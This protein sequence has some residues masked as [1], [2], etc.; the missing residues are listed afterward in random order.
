MRKIFSNPAVFSIAL[1]ISGCT[2]YQ[3]LPLAQHARLAEHIENIRHTLPALAGETA[4]TD[5]DITRPLTVAQIGLLAI[6]NAPELQTER[7]EQAVAEA[8]LIQ[9]A[10]LP[11]PSVG[12]GYAALLG[13]PGT[14][15][16]YTASLSQDIAS[17]VTYRRRVAAARAGVEQVNANLLWK[18]WQVAQKA[19]LLAVD[20]YWGI[21]SIS[22]ME[23]ELALVSQTT[24]DVRNAVA[25]GDMGL[26]DLAPVQDSKATTERSLESLRESQSANWQSLD[27][28]L[29][30][31]P[32]V[33]F[34]IAKPNLP[35]LP[36][37]SDALVANV[38]SRRPDLVALQLGYR[39]ADESVRAAILGQFPALVLGGTWG[40]DTS[41]IRSAG[42][43]VT[44]D[45]PIFD[46]NQ[47]QVAQTQATR[48]LL[49]EQYQQQLDDTVSSILGLQAKSQRIAATLETARQAAMSAR[50]HANTARSAYESR[51]IDQRT[52]TDYE[53][54]SLQRTTEVFDLERGLDEARVALA[55]ELGLGLPSARIAP[56]DQTR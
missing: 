17:L 49:H 2:S 11:N 45:L 39:S 50:S 48:L 4:A 47:G 6:L 32:E 40:S 19:Q 20:L 8:Q 33:R 53:T 41:D 51:D 55:L 23:E 22:A 36:A 44:F 18:E 25:A 1:V 52:L 43:V 46:H 16:A 34:A 29:G 27:A 35:A 12:L 15:G 42:P 5:I 56:L 30:M 24:S 26:A 13:G 9:S 37:D 3:P 28:L 38:Q 21:R 7:G 31:K 14:T 10:M 54:T